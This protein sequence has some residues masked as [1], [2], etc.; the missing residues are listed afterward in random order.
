M[1]LSPRG[2]ARGKGSTV[3]PFCEVTVPTRAGERCNPIKKRWGNLPQLSPHARARGALKQME[4]FRFVSITVPT[5]AGER[6]NKNPG[7][8]CPKVS[9]VP[10]RAGER[11]NPIKKRWGNLPQ[12]SPHARARGATAAVVPPPMPLISPQASKFAPLTR[13]LFRRPKHR[14]K[15]SSCVLRFSSRVLIPHL[16]KSRTCDR[17]FRVS[18]AADA[19]APSSSINPADSISRITRRATTFSLADKLRPRNAGRSY[20]TQC[21]PRSS[22][23][24]SWQA[25]ISRSTRKPGSPLEFFRSFFVS[26]WKNATSAFHARWIPRSKSSGLM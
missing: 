18:R 20:G 26:R 17:P 7:A 24:C 8:T 12:L 16:L 6:C 5:R 25:A 3:K 10:T 13:S 19:L 14:V 11:C 15:P 9:A 1:V 23:S 4:G 22:R 2:R 21:S